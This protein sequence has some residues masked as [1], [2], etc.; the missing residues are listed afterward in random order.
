M[1]EGFAN[2]GRSA[3]PKA[4]EQLDPLEP[5]RQL[6]ARGAY[7]Q[8]MERLEALHASVLPDL[9]DLEVIDTLAGLHLL[10]QSYAQLPS[11][12]EPALKRFP[13]H[14]GLLGKLA[15]AWRNLGQPEHAVPLWRQARQLDPSN[16]DLAYN[17]GNALRDSGELEQAAECFEE[18]L[19][20]GLRDPKVY[21]NLGIVLRDLK[22]LARAEQ[23]F[24]QGLAM[25]PKDRSLAFN[26]S[27]ILAERHVF[28][29][30]IAVLRQ[31]PADPDDVDVLLNLALSLDGA[32]QQNEALMHLQRVLEL[33]AARTDALSALGSCYQT[34][35]QIEKALATYDAALAIDPGNMELHR[36]KSVC[37]RYQEG[38]AHLQQMRHLCSLS[39]LDDDGRMRLYFALAK[40]EEEAGN[41]RQAFQHL[42]VGNQLMA[43]VVEPFDLQNWIRQTL[44]MLECDRAAIRLG[45]G[46][47]DPRKGEGLVFIL[48]MPRSGTTL[49]ENILSL[50]PE[51]VDLG[52]TMALQRC[53]L[54]METCW[55][56][57]EGPSPAH[58]ETLG[59]CYLERIGVTPSAE[60]LVT[61]KNLYNWRY[62]GLIARAFPSARIIHC[63]RNPMDNLLSIYK[64]FFPQGNEYAFDLGQIFQMYQLHDQAMGPYQQR[65]PTQ[66]FTSNYDDLVRE[67]AE[68]IPEL[69]AFVGLPWTEHYLHPETSQRLVRTASAVQVRQP[70]HA[71]S[72]RGWTRYE[73]ELQLVAQRFR[74]LG[75][76]VD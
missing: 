56:P 51:A 52:E 47:A 62:A 21:N 7:G 67:P 4:S 9:Q 32:G 68:R 38:D 63:R 27:G 61:D 58:L 46:V 44:L 71:R 69:V 30:S 37:R 40:A 8:A 64:A 36:R 6:I 43:A 25:A 10:E 59:D 24:S 28:D 1:T 70:I 29:E 45:L 11:L 73:T 39:T 60:R 14:Q 41:F 50:A 18:A 76:N 34:T 54:E 42:Q 72:V 31:L 35:G 5:V 49:T 22:Q 17:L 33:D 16:A 26:L 23:A 12:L 74:D 65:Y 75:Y 19:A 13:A 48:G 3:R 15:T 20:L 57:S 2:A 55:D 53:V 66:I